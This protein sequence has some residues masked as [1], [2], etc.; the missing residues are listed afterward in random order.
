M[1]EPITH[2]LG[3]AP[4]EGMQTVIER[5]AE[6]YPNIQ[7]DAYT[8]DLEEGVAIVRNSQMENYDVIISRGGT[9][10]RIREVTDLPVVSVQ[11]SVYDILRAIKMAENY[12]HLYAIIGFPAITEPAHILCDLLRLD[13]DIVTIH[14]VDEADRALDRLQEGGYKMV[15]SDMV[16]HT[17]ARQ[18]GFDAFLVTSGTES[19]HDAFLRAVQISDRFRDMRRQNLLLEGITRSSAGNTVVLDSSGRFVYATK[20]TPQP[21]QIEFLRSKIPDIPL[22]KPL[23]F[24]HEERGEFLRVTARSMRVGRE[25]YYSFHC[26][27]SQVSLRSGKNGIRFYNKAEAQQLFMNSFYSISGA[28]GLLEESVNFIA[29]TRQPVMILGEAGTGKEQIARALY[30]R[31]QRANHPLAVVDCSVIT[32]KNWDFLLNHYSSPLNEDSCTV[33]FQHLEYLSETY[34]RELLGVVTGTNLTKRI[35]LIFSAICATDQPVPEVVQTIQRR[36]GCVSMQLPTLRSRQ[37]ELPSLASLYLSNLN[38]EL[39]KQIIGFDPRAME[40]LLHY[41]WPNNYTQFKQVLQE[42]AAKTEFTY[43][44]SSVVAEVL[45]RE[46]RAFRTNTVPATEKTISGTLDEIIQGAIQRTLEAVGGNQTV[47]AKSLGISR[48]TLWRYLNRKGDT[49][50]L[51]S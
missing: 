5:I 51:S 31:S 23:R 26:Q 36:L 3:I 20:D 21:D 34:C 50:S 17:L 35:R 30:V 15:L 47:A 24:F 19:F 13:M 2:I 10:D 37:D 8:A 6:E 1:E 22:S 40:Q 33:Y 29:P 32:D 44:R 28:M 4:Y 9:A 18:K 49:K 39:G 41:E 11:L 14:S 16:T 27:T 43:I 45:S 46:R 48:T 42:L 7:L 25:R 12:S 38:A